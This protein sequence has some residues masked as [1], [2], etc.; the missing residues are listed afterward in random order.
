MPLFSSSRSY[1]NT[2]WAYQ[3][4]NSSESSLDERHVPSDER[5][6]PSDEDREHLSEFANPKRMSHAT[7][8]PPTG[9]MHSVGSQ[10]QPVYVKPN[11]VAEPVTVAQPVSEKL[12]EPVE[13]SSECDPDTF[14]IYKNGT[15]KKIRWSNSKNKCVLGKRT[16][17]SELNSGY[18][19][20]I[21]KP[22]YIN[23]GSRLT[24]KMKKQTKKSK[25]HKKTNNK[26]KTLI[27][28]CYDE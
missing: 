1:P 11:P 28:F 23:G 19:R 22:P 5:H 4:V 20:K 9:D 17:I 24:K 12:S 8:Y 2:K 26:E 16:Y 3:F 10:P 21:D 14:Y 18:Y 6:V 15:F 27:S 7:R 13:Q 25:S